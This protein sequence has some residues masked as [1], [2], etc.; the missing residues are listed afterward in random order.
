[1][2]QKAAVV[3]CLVIFA[4]LFVAATFSTPQSN[5]DFL[6]IHIRA[7]SNDP[8]DQTVKYLVKDE[9]VNYLAPFLASATDKESARKI[10][11]AHLDGIERT[12]DRVLK[13]NGFDYLSRAE[14]KKEEFPVRQYENL[15]LDSGVYDALI[16]NL[17]SGTGDNW[18]CVVY[19]PLCFVGG[20][21]NGTN[22]IRYKSKLL[23]LIEQFKAAFEK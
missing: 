2:K 18:W 16:L 11:S 9:I 15:V 8:V 20:E 14:L 6:R 23:E 19:P 7:N 1:M 5:E 22:Q 21:L 3:L 17:G 10:V 13:A 4:V 12:A